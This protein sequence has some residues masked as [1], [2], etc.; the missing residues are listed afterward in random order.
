MRGCCNGLTVAKNAI[1]GPMLAIDYDRWAAR[2]DDTR[3][4][5]PSVLRPMLKALGRPDRR[6]LLEIGSGTGNY[7]LALSRVRFTVTAC[8]PS[9]GMVAR[10]STKVE[11]ALIAAGQA[12]PFR[13]SAFDCAV[14]VK[15]LNHVP[16]RATFM[17][18]AFRVVREGPLVLVHATKESIKGNWIS[19]YFSAI[20]DDARF[21][22]EA[23]TVQ[24]MRDA[25]FRAVDVSHIT[26]QDTD[27]GSAQALKYRPEAFL[28]DKRIMNTSLLSRQPEGVRAEALASIRA[29]YASGKLSDVIA[30]YDERS[31]RGGDGTAFVGRV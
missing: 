18:E 20:L 4:V 1:I 7:A 26:Y 14:A 30:S 12:L 8:D 17:Q 22:P 24:Q 27:D 10:A 31:R 13:D 19:H 15:V 6:S 11:R 29:D 21:E 9:A 23:R 3:G 5:S 2:Y 16:D 25:G 28:T